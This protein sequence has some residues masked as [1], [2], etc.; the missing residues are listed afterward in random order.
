MTRDD[1]ADVFS[2]A[3]ERSAD[4]TRWWKPLGGAGGGGA[5]PATA[6][7][8]P[9]PPPP[10][11]VA[12]TGG[13]SARGESSDAAD[14]GAA[15]MPLPVALPLPPLP[16]LD[17]RAACCTGVDGKRAVAGPALGESG[18]LAPD[19]AVDCRDD[20]AMPGV[21]VVVVVVVGGVAELRC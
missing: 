16:V 13:G 7:L 2:R 19:C 9:P 8:A 11:S 18:G 5:D 3:L 21:G 6:P 17:S 4:G 1:D 20:E 14:D 15:A 12:S 10:P